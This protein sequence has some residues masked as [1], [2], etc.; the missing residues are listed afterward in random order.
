MIW[1]IWLS[2]FATGFLLGLLGGR[3][4]VWKKCKALL[5]L[6]HQMQRAEMNALKA[7]LGLGDPRKKDQRPH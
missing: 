2:W 1:T 6:S 3:I 4:M 5:D 7:A